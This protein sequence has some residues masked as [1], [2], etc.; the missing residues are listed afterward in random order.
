MGLLR[1]P[2]LLSVYLFLLIMGILFPVPAAGFELLISEWLGLL[3]SSMIG[4][5]I[6]IKEVLDGQVLGTVVCEE[7]SLL[8]G[9]VNFR[10]FILLVDGHCDPLLGDEIEVFL[11]YT[12][13]I[14]PS[15]CNTYNNDGRGIVR[16]NFGTLRN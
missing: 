16:Q 6:L 10:P 14:H 5:F 9:H 11:S 8:S 1:T 2:R 12:Q 15:R 13:S 4:N 3:D 7:I